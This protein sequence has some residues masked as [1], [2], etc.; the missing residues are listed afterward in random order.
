MKNGW[1]SVLQA[2]RLARALLQALHTLP[3]LILLIIFSLHPLAAANST[4][5]GAV[6]SPYPTFIHLAVEWEVTGDDNLNCTVSVQYRKA[7]DSQ[8]RQGMPLRRIPAGQSTGTSPTF[9]WKNKLSGS[10]FSLQPDTQYE[11]HLQL[12]DPDGGSVERTLLART[13]A[14]PCTAPDSVVKYVTPATYRDSSQT[15]SPGDVLVL[16]PGNYGNGFTYRSGAAGKPIVLRADR[17]RPDSLV[18]FDS[19]SLRGAKYIILEGITVT[20]GTI[21]LQSAEEVAV[22]RCTVN[23]DYGIVADDPPGAKNCYIADNVVTSTNTWVGSSMGADGYNEGE[24]IQLTGPGNVICFNLVKGYRDCISFMEDNSTADQYCIDVYNN[25]I[26]VGVDDAI[27]A[28]FCQ[29]NCRIIRNRITNC[30]MGLSSQ[31][32]LGGPTYFIRNVMYNI[33]DC[34]FKLARYSKGDVCLHNTIVKVGD[35]FRVIHNPTYAYFRN[36]L[37][38]G[39]SGGGS[40]GSYGSGDGRAMEFPYAD[41]TTSLDYDG[42]GTYG[43]P[44]LAKW[45]NIRTYSIEDMRAQTP[46]KHAVLVD[47]NVFREGVEWPAPAVPEREPADLRLRPGS[48][49][50]DAGIAIPNVND[51][52][53]GLAPDL[54]AYEL[55]SDMPHY[56]PRPESATGN[57]PCDYSGDGFVNLIDVLV[58]LLDGRKDL[59]NPALD[60]NGDGAFNIADALSLLSDISHGNCPEYYYLL[61]S[62][63]SANSAGEISELSAG[64]REYLIQMLGRMELSEQ[65]EAEFYR[66]IYGVSGESALPRSF[67]LAQNSPNPFN[68]STTISFDIPAGESRRMALKGFDV[69]GKLVRN[70]V[71]GIR[72]PG[73]HSVF[74]DGMDETGR[75]V[76]SGVYFYRMESGDFSRSRKMVLLK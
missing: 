18:K 30:F 20:G 29:G 74:W 70:L 11:I 49:A 71:E 34:P 5:P 7:G 64:E 44:F 17:S 22:L 73:R 60:R 27:E 48:V 21:D 75:K 50:V 38:L 42:V 40:F 13:R 1:R 43:T 56:G 59:Q 51:N 54:G 31:P 69:R 28:D 39:G 23:S 67:A 68:P 47:L 8:W 76:A 45:G 46:E 14:I 63:A 19:F 66:V 4:L 41:S 55:G 33:I 37:T 6:T 25:D 53:S 65:Q 15:S 12:E 57:A 16:A 32:G 62:T 3:V 36:N 72:V 9:Y 26:Y 52:F 10:L 61:S 2:D 58:L 35:G 24:G